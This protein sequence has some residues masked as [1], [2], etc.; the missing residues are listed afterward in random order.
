MTRWFSAEE[1]ETSKAEFLDI[2]LYSREQIKSE[3]EE[4]GVGHQNEQVDYDWGIVSIKPQ[5][6][7]K[8]L[9]MAPITML[10]NAL[11]KEEGGSGVKLDKEKY[12]ESVD[13]FKKFALVK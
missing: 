6:V 1:V 11:G 8:E 9:P 10:R 12:N 13:F 7:D 5:G 4:T 2:I 3:N